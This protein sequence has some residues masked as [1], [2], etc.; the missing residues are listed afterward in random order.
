MKVFIIAA[1]TADGFIARSDADSSL[2]WTSAEDK[3]MY[4]AATKEAGIMVFGARTFATIKRALPG[5]KT[6]VYTHHPEA[7]PA[8]DG[9]EPT[10]E[11]PAALLKRLEAEGAQQVAICGGSHIYSLFM[12]AGLV[13][14]LWLTIEPL[15]FGSGVLLLSEPCDAKLELVEAKHLS[16]QTL[17]HIYKVIR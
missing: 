12:K 5:R 6:I 1:L 10:S 4:R 17:Q 13:D 8:M 7:I 14:E 15:M 16:D 11:E 9:V 3:A 2:T